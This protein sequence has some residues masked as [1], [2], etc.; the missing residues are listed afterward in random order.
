MASTLTAP[1]E[2]PAEVHEIEGGGY[3]AELPSL[4]GCV[5]QAET[6]EALRENIRLALADWMA[7]S[8]VKNTGRPA[9]SRPYRAPPCHRSRVFPSPMSIGRH[10]HGL[11]RMSDGPRSTAPPPIQYG[12]IVF[13]EIPDPNG[14]NTKI[15]RV[16]HQRSQPWI[17][18]TERGRRR[19]RGALACPGHAAQLPAP[20]PGTRHPPPANADPRATSS[21]FPPPTTHHPPPIT[22][23]E[24]RS[25]SPTRDRCC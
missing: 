23:P 19:G 2:I 5:A 3:W 8:T 13:A 1:I 11:M 16:V 4:P 9:N 12:D 18:R 14:L 20:S 7:Q 24:W 6:M 21:Q 17:R 15:R 25:S 22:S 10:R